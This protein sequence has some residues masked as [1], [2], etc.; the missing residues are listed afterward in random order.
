MNFLGMGPLELVVILVIALIVFG[1]GKLTEISGTLG[2]S[3]RE[4]RRA[5]SEMTQELSQSVGEV[6]QPLEE[7][8]RFPLDQQVAPVGERVRQS[9][10]Q[11]T[12]SVTCP[13]C[14]APNPE[15]NKFCG[16]CGA[17]I[18]LAGAEGE[19]KKAP[20]SDQEQPAAS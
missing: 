5:A 10:H 15:A 20:T 14:A 7:I 8:R 12:S 1:P 11:G 19:V 6:R 17:E 18:V 2:R 16:S 4:F 3:V 13:Q 9:E